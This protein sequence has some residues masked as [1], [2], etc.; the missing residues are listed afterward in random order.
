[1]GKELHINDIMRNA[2]RQTE[3]YLNRTTH[4]YQPI[5]SED[6]KTLF[7]IHAKRVLL[8]K[9]MNHDFVIDDINKEVINM[10]FRYGFYKHKSELNTLAGIVLNGRYGC[11]KSVMMSTFCRLLSD[12]AYNDRDRITEVHAI[13]LAES[14]KINGITPYARK[15]LLIQDLG[16]EPN[17]VNDYG[18]QIN[19][20]SNLLAV[21][22]EYGALTFGTTNMSIK[23]FGEQYKEYISKRIT[24][25][26]NLVMLPGDSRRV[27]QS[28]NQPKP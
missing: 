15:P 26:V 12:V 14:I 28:F 23:S 22:A 8:E 11:G 3:S 21:R 6:F 1:M 20:I 10:L 13:E 9:N 17:I 25:H 4:V 19:P 2:I 18:T 27:D 24:E 16:K 5:T 7:L